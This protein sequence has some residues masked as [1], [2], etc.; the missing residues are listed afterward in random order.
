MMQFCFGTAT[1]LPPLRCLWSFSA[2]VATGKVKRPIM[3]FGLD[4]FLKSNAGQRLQS[5]REPAKLRVHEGRW[6][7]LAGAAA[8]AR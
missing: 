8:S 1:T 3:Q 5:P 6:T 4:A 2:Y 7:A